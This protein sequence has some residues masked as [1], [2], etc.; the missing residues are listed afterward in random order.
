MTIRV[1]Q[2]AGIGPVQAMGTPV[3]TALEDEHT[4]AGVRQIARDRR[5]TGAR[6][7]DDDVKFLRGFPERLDA[8]HVLR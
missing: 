7:H 8:W 5:A 4:P 6:A 2:G 3:T 1:Q